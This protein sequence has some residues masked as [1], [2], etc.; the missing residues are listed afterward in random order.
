MNNFD[1]KNHWI[2]PP[3]GFLWGFPRVWRGTP[4]LKTWL[5]S[6]GYPKADVDWAMKYLRAWPAD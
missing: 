3:S 6:F 1:L 4:D 5:L 2:D